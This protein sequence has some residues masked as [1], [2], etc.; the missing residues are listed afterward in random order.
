MVFEE[1]LLFLTNDDPSAGVH[2]ELTFDPSNYTDPGEV[3]IEFYYTDDDYTGA[4]GFGIDDVFLGDITWILE[5]EEV[6][7]VDLDV[8][9]ELEVSFPDW[10]PLALGT[11]ENVDITYLAEAESMLP[12]DENP[13]NDYKSK[14]FI[15][16]YGF[17]HDLGVNEIVSPD[18]GWAD[19]FTPMCVV[20]NYG[21]FDET[22]AEVNLMIEKAEYTL[23]LEEDF[24]GTFPP[25]D[26]VVTNNG[27]TCV[28]E[29]NDVWGR[30][31]YA[32]GDGYCAD[33]DS[34][35]C[36]SG[37][38]MDTDLITPSMDLSTVTGAMFSFITSYNDISSGATSDLAMVDI[39]TDGGTTWTNLLTWDE[40]HD[41]SGP[42][43]E[44]MIDLSP[45]CGNADVQIKFHYVA[46]G[47]DWWWE[48]DQVKVYEV[49]FTTEFDET[50]Q[51]DIA[52]GETMNVTFPEW[53]PND[54]LS[55]EIDYR[56]TACTSLYT[57]D[58]IACEGFED[59]DP[60]LSPFPYDPATGGTWG[61]YNIDN[62]SKEWELD[63]SHAYTGDYGCSVGYN[64]AGQ[65]DW[66][67]TPD[68]PVLM[69]L[70]N[71]TFDVWATSTSSYYLEDFE[72]LSWDWNANGGP[73]VVTPPYTGWTLEATYLQIPNTWTL[74]STPI[75]P[76]VNN[77]PVSVA[78]RCISVDELRLA[79]DDIAMPMNGWS[80]DFE[81]TG[82][83]GF[84]PA[85]WTI[86]N[87]SGTG[88][89]CGNSYGAHS[90]EPPG[91]GCDYAN[92]WDVSGVGF[93]T[94][95][96]TPAFDLTGET[97]VAVIFERNFQDFA[98]YGQATVNTYSGSAMTFEEELLWLDVDDPSGGVHT[99]L[100][101]DP[102]S[103]TDWSEVYIG[104]W[105]TDDAYSSTAWG[106]SIDDVCIAVP[107]VGD[108]NPDND[109][110]VK[111]I[112]L[113]YSH[114]V[115]VNAITEPSGPVARD[116]WD[117]QF[118]FD[119]NAASGAG[120][121]AG[122]EFDGTYFYTTRWAS[123][124]IHRYDAAGNLVEE[125]SI[126]GVTGLRDLAYDGTYFYGGNSGN[127]IYVMDF[128][129]YTLVDT[130]SSS[131]AV[132]AIA[133]DEDRDAF[134]VSNWGDPVGVIARDGSTIE[135]FDLLT[136]T[137]T[138]GFA[139]ENTCGAEPYL[140]VH[141]QTNGGSVIHQWDLTNYQFTGF[142]FD[143]GAQHGSGSGIA[144][145]LFT[146]PDFRL[147]TYTIGGLVQDSDAPG[148]GDYVFCYELCE[149]GPGN[150]W[151][152]GTYPVEAIIEN[153]GSFEENNFNVNAQ[154]WELT[155]GKADDL[156]WEDDFMVTTPLPREGTQL[157]AFND[158][159]FEDT[160][161]AEYELRV[162]T[163]L[164]IDDNPINDQ[165]KL[166][167]TIEI[168][169]TTPPVTTHEF[170]GE[171]GEEDWYV[172]DVYITLTAEDPA[173]D[174]GRKPS[175]VAATYYKLD[176]GAEEEYIDPILVADD[177][178]HTIEY[179]SVDNAGNWEDW[180]G[181]FDF[182]IDQTPPEI[183]E[184]T[185]EN[186]GFRKWLLSLDVNDA[187]SGVVKVE[188]YVDD[189]LVGEVTSEPWEY[190]YQG[191]GEQAQAI[192]YDEAGNSAASDKI[193]A[194]VQNLMPR[195]NVVLQHNW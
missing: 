85:G 79:V 75:T 31:N 10:T 82:P 177:G 93:D 102:S 106:F 159:T 104:F 115:G 185:A 58:P 8:E 65:D 19:S 144:G 62:D 24:E 107:G 13:D 119:C 39:S 128:N 54:L 142:T 72:I 28:W 20:E 108:G 99:V 53:T 164:D 123:N 194:Q 76:T 67:V 22:G 73:P 86:V 90:Y 161:E 7:N 14:E 155:G 49:A 38:T 50:V 189:E 43:E 55:F 1:E 171:M 137:S 87:Y 169:D 96:F 157:I 156:F 88:L 12:G 109:C 190:E 146:T 145:G 94:E 52:A 70:A 26:W 165:K 163:E 122:S 33:A 56:V 17:F 166:K 46:P 60:G 78:I 40:D 111:W 9:E 47:W 127:S 81:G 95:L 181:P 63:S 147:G 59:F 148:V 136:T 188:F 174:G 113:L 57:W 191:G 105:F 193:D 118:E 132:R 120:G 192:A 74:Y 138:Y 121:N 37:T 21:Q 124:L 84:P 66:L 182:K 68:A 195:S 36:G 103:Y 125:F 3:Y 48:V 2:T 160:D 129:T 101:F 92:A 112:S 34:D 69:G 173:K 150:V 97:A 187:T 126:P 29:R 71:E 98:G 64:Y 16:H 175:G 41:A 154:I 61:I 143:T 131:V 117:L 15:L 25:A 114:D 178:E 35:A 27:G 184:F 179:R 18:D 149:T 172:S 139:W 32:G 170:S 135:T 100:V 23:Y 162:T 180:K 176:G 140:W 133:Y 151:P 42:G 51:I 141:D 186:T 158:V 77:G 44:V 110:L 183:I 167:F 80:Y 89:W 5:Y 91:T 134:I 153:F 11:Q 30:P 116:P 130:I 168:P 4:W 6:V 152:P 83:T 45:Y